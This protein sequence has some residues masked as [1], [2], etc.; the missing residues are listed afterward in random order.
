MADKK[1]SAACYIRDHPR[2]P[3]EKQIFSSVRG[4]K[5]EMIVQIS[6]RFEALG[7]GILKCQHV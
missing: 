7:F 2:Y 3:R 6:L 5:T 1:L 4:S